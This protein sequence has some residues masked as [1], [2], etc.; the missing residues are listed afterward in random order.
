[1][2]R[3]L[4]AY[5]ECNNILS[6][7]QFGFRAGKSTDDAINE[8]LNDAYCS[9]DRSE[10]FA[11][12]C[13]D[14][15]KAFD[16]V[17]HDIL[18][19]KLHHLGLRGITYNWFR[20]YLSDRVSYVSVSKVNSTTR[21]TQIGV[22]QGSNLGPLLF[23]LYVNDM[24]S[25]TE[26]LKL[27]NFAD[28]TTVYMSNSNIDTLYVRLS[29]ELARIGQWLQVNR[30]SLNIDK[31]NYMIVTNRKFISRAVQLSGKN[32]KIADHIFFLGVYVDKS[33]SFK[34]HAQNLVKKV[35]SAI[36]M[37]RRVSNLMPVN[38]RLK[39]YYALIYSRISYAVTIWGRT[40]AS[41]ISLCNSALKRAWKVVFFCHKGR[42]FP[43]K[44]C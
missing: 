16:T 12:V 41:N 38:V 11:A 30:L 43:V 27:I 35:S 34:K 31:T 24:R 37:I 39:I 22:P 1:M 2:C 6:P 33:L 42:S 9:L 7:T 19:R 23:L 18:L 44:K 32:V 3:R 29:D 14:L 8:F 25:S 20:S 21:T 5:V 28:D 17:N 15:S 40:L 26:G 36:G 4:T 13:L 10:Y